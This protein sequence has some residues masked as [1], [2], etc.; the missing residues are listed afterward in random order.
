MT[1]P[2]AS[3]KDRT[4]GIKLD[5]VSRRQLRILAKRR[6]RSVH[7]PMKV[8]IARRLE[9]EVAGESTG[10]PRDGP[11]EPKFK[12]DAKATKPI[13]AGL[14]AL[15]ASRS[16]MATTGCGWWSRVVRGWRGLTRAR[17]A[18]MMEEIGAEASERGLEEIEN[19]KRRPDAPLWAILARL[20]DV[21]VDDLIG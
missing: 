21:S 3:S 16:R 5:P 9:R 17:L 12:K 1:R 18:A 10:Y 6:N 2:S 19:D 15:C 8:A 7:A 4:T 11:I 14:P 13:A 20:L